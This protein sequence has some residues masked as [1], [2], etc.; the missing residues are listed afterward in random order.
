MMDIKGSST[1]IILDPSMGITDRENFRHSAT[2]SQPERSRSPAM[3]EPTNLEINTQII[4]TQTS[5]NSDLD[6]EV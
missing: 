1:Q 4:H 2:D 3:T 6:H 5:I